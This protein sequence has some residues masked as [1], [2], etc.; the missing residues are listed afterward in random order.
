MVLYSNMHPRPALQLNHRKHFVSTFVA[1]SP[2]RKMCA[3][4]VRFKKFPVSCHWEIY[5]LPLPQ[6]GVFFLP[7]RIVHLRNILW[8]VSAATVNI[9]AEWRRGKAKFISFC[10]KTLKLPVLRRAEKGGL[11]SILKSNI[12]EVN[13]QET[14]KYFLA[15]SVTIVKLL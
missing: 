12:W 14:Q 7:V 8:D 5:H 15:K 11:I 4:T 2:F 1:L 10:G 6:A 3:Q 9:R 13:G